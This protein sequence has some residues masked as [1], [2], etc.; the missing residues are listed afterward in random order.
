MS[1]IVL[2]LTLREA[3]ELWDALD[4]CACGKGNGLIKSKLWAKLGDE[5]DKR[6]KK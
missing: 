6:S 4:Y 3:M 2:R 5:I 1:K